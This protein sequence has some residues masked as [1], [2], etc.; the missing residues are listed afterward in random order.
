VQPQ[1]KSRE[2]F[3]AWFS[4]LAKASRKEWDR[5]RRRPRTLPFLITED[6]VLEALQ[7]APV[8]RVGRLELEK[9]S[10]SITAILNDAQLQ[11]AAPIQSKFYGVHHEVQ[12]R[13]RQANRAKAQAVH[14]HGASL[15]R[16]LRTGAVHHMAKELLAS[17]RA[18]LRDIQ[19]AAGAHV[20]HRLWRMGVP[21]TTIADLLARAGL[22]RRS[23]AAIKSLLARSK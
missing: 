3:V 23:P 21:S 7:C 1:P 19:A 8:R 14:Q 10:A 4:R 6:S 22:P 17:I 16:R 9:H 15:K 18:D 11:Y 12:R 5:A 20:I 2:P 13:V